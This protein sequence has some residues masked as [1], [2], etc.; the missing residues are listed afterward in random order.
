MVAISFA[1]I[2]FRNAINIG[3]P[4]VECDTSPIRDGDE[5]MVDVEGGVV[6][7]LTQGSRIS[8]SPVPAIMAAILQA[9]GLAAYIKL[10]GDLV[11]PETR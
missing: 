11:L 6:Q 5:V 4:V 2:F 1:R 3:L 7:D 9:G 8:T 10:H